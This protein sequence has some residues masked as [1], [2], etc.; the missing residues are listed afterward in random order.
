MIT[1]HLPILQVI[2]PL[3]A[4]PVCLLLRHAGRCWWL[5]MAVSTATLI[6]AATLLSIV[7]DAGP[8]TY[9]LGGW[10]PP[11][12]IEYRIDELNALV[13]LIVSG[14]STVTLL[15]SR[16]SLEHEVHE[17]RRYI[18]YT[19]WMLCLC[20]LLGMAATGDL[21]NIFVF[22]EISS[23][24]MYLMIALGQDRR[25]LT[26]AFSY[27]VMGTIGATF[28]LIGVALL[29]ALTGTLNLEDMAER[30]TAAGDS[31][32]VLTA[33][34]FILLGVGVK[35]AIFPLHWWLP[36]AYRYAPT[37]ATALLAGTATKV[38]V[39][40]IIRFVFDL[41]GMDYSFASL[42]LT[43]VLLVAGV[44]AS[45]LMSAVAIYQ[46]DIKKL[47]A[48]SS[49]AQI[50]YMVIGISLA[51]AAGL[52]ASLLHLF[53]HAVIKAALF[54]ALGA[55]FVRTGGYRLEDLHGIGR[56]MPWTMAALLIAG[57]SLVGVPLT[58]GFISKWYLI[59]AALE[60]D[61]LWLAI[62]VVASSLLAVMYVW[63]IVEAGYFKPI[64]EHVTVRRE[65]GPGLLVPLWI[66]VVANV[67]FGI[68]T[69]LNVGAASAA[70]AALT[71][72]SP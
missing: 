32:A 10:P 53:N 13:L 46:D 34:A 42:D 62:A 51:S 20:G 59:L 48:Y 19:A 4:A 39:Y 5:A 36:D 65:A 57:L 21:F 22:L 58:A 23:L 38:A 2:L 31:R 68:E 6:T 67:Y 50:G 14:I 12:G 40:L 27:L 52:T 30:L 29:Y 63:R 47:F 11:W 44:A 28:F 49:V 17:N 70:A 72:G 3:I 71:G 35:A 66:L 43:G 56:Y 9:F 33:Y 26:A 54:M 24:S 61:R 16:A 69:S 18:Y 45:L 15:F 37:S 8:L 25:A 55:A 64:P 1:H 41:F 60:G 7:H